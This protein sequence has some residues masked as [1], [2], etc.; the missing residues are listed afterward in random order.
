MTLVDRRSR[1]GRRRGSTL[2]LVLIMGALLVG[3]A[4][5]TADVARVGRAVE[6]RDRANSSLTYQCESATELLRLELMRDWE[7]SGFTPSTWLGQRLRQASATTP[8]AP[9]ADVTTAGTPGDPAGYPRTFAQFPDVRVWVDRVGAPGQNWLEVVASTAADVGAAAAD[10]RV[11][12]SVRIRLNWGN[13]PIFDLAMLTV[14]TNCMFCHMK[15]QGDVGSIGYFRPGWGQPAGHPGGEQGDNSG[16]D[17]F[18]SGSLYTAASTIDMNGLN[19]VNGDMANGTT[20]AGGQLFKDYTG[21]KLP[22]DTFGNDGVPDFPTIDPVQARQAAKGSVWAGNANN[23]DAASGVWVVPLGGDFA[24]DKV[25]PTEASFTSGESGL[26]NATGSVINGNLVLVGT[27]DNPIKLNGDVFVEGDVVIKGVVEGKGAIYSGRNTY[28]AGDVIYKDAPTGWSTGGAPTADGPLKDDAGAQSTVVNEASAT[29]L[30]LA[31]RGN[32]VVGDYTYRGDDDASVQQMKYRQGQDFMMAQFQLW[33]TRYF[34]VDDQSV[35]LIPRDSDGDGAFDD[36]DDDGF[37]DAFYNDQGAEVA[38]PARVAKASW[39]SSVGNAAAFDPDLYNTVVAPGT[40]ERD[41]QGKAVFNPWLK[42]KEYRDFLGTKEYSDMTWRFESNNNSHVTQELGAK[43]TNGWPSNWSNWRSM[44][45]WQAWFE[46]DKFG[47]DK[48]QFVYRDGNTF[49]V[50]ETGA[51]QWPTQVS[52]ID[53]F[54]YANGRIGGVTLGT[55]LTINGGMAAREIGILAPGVK[56]SAWWSSRDRIHSSNTHKNNFPSNGSRW[57]ANVP[58]N[59]PRRRLYLNYD[60]RLRNG[61]YGYNLVEG[62]AGDATI[63]QRGPALTPPPAP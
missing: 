36:G 14:S 50:M 34:D 33:N 10:T 32:I 61:G 1:A 3:V 4:L 15:I 49:R 41:A 23:D 55:G 13:N 47:A 18:V 48:G 2:V 42:D 26:T 30:R 24:T 57:W 43:P 63:F 12:Q 9:R 27:E 44:S 35:E 5:V 46:K 6:S 54:L 40:V 7:A 16:S 56:E 22:K 38:D 60:Y 51:K 25:R 62:G 53:G 17:S 58:E 8:A 21:P 11:G 28:I 45:N 37:P 20:W 31:A 29:E 52:R 59:D 19:G 39:D